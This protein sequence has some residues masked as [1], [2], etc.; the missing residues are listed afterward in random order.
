MDNLN[1]VLNTAP[2]LYGILNT[3]V[4]D[5]STLIGKP[6]INGVLLTG[7]ISSDELNIGADG[8]TI[9]IGTTV[10]GNAGTDATVI[11]SGTSK[12]VILNFTIP[13]GDPGERAPQ[14][15]WNQIDNSA[16]DYIKN[17][18]CYEDIVLADIPDLSGVV[19]LSSGLYSGDIPSTIQV[20]SGITSF[21][22]GQLYQVIYNDAS[23]LYKAYLYNGLPVIGTQD[24]FLIALDPQMGFMIVT[25]T[26]ES[27]EVSINITKVISYDLK[28]IDNKFIDTDNI[29]NNSVKIY[30]FPRVIYSDMADKLEIAMQEVSEGKAI[31]NWNGAIF[32]YVLEIVAGEYMVLSDPNSLF[33]YLKYTRFE[34][35]GIT[36]YAEDIGSIYNYK[37]VNSDEIIIYDN[38]YTHSSSLTYDDIVGIKQLLNMQNGDE[39]SY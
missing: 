8:S 4:A 14:A 2:Q 20:T 13:K 16:D 24:S 22:D 6:S 26:T 23:Y 38:T 36:K 5:Y 7:N 17:R 10:T 34:E 29:L 25:N 3:V 12:D 28:Q 21:I 1:G 18:V 35:D 32:T 30:T 27:I 19:T 39:V 11:N 15:D 31:V 9:N 37:P 33:R